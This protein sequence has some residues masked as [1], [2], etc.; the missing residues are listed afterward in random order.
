MEN[1]IKMDDLGE[2]PKPS[3]LGGKNY[4]FGEE[5]PIW[6][7]PTTG[8]PKRIVPAKVANIMCQC[9]DIGGHMPGD[10]FHG[11]GVPGGASKLVGAFNP[12]EKTCSSNWT[13]SPSMGQNKKNES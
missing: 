12:S 9:C 6:R 8:L 4:I 3:I 10:V 5:T 13:F 7:F 11:H 2:N 1:P